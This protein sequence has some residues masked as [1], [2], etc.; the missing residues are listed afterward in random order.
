MTNLCI[1]Y[2][3]SP[4]DGYNAILSTGEP[5]TFFSVIF[6]TILLIYINH[7]CYRLYKSYF[8]LFYCI[9][10]SYCIFLFYFSYLYFSC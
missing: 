7:I 5:G 9:V 2:L 6:T 4:L 8:I 3:A 1:V 10:Y